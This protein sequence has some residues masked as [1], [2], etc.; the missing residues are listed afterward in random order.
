MGT[1]AITGTITE[2]VNEAAIVTGSKTLIITLTGDT[3]IGEGAGASYLLQDDFEGPGYE[4][5]TWTETGATI[6]DQY[7]TA[8]APLVGSYSL[9]ITPT[10]TF[11]STKSPQ[12]TASDTVYAY[13]QFRINTL[14]TT[15]NQ[16]KIFS[17]WNGGTELMAVYQASSKL[18]IKVPTTNIPGTTTLDTNTT[19]HMWV[20]YTRGTGADA[21]GTMWLS[22]SA[23]KPGAPEVTT[24]EGAST[25]QADYISLRSS[26]GGTYTVDIIFDKVRVSDSDIGSDPQ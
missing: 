11:R 2:S 26:N 20:R 7:A 12:F 23:T 22:D 4:S 19:Y 15:A 16:V 14:N 13:F 6:D 18:Q 21:V 10:G 9:Y 24:S 3:W 5:G 17:I 25:L 8:P 1:A